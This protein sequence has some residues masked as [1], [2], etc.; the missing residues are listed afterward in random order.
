MPFQTVTK[1]QYMTEKHLETA[2][3]QQRQNNKSSMLHSL[4]V[5]TGCITAL[6]L[7]DKESP[8]YGLSNIAISGERGEKKEKNN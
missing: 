4:Q 2:L 1:I 5:K 3:E 7:G 8:N 6:R